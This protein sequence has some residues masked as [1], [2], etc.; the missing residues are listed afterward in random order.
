MNTAIICS[1]NRWRFN[2]V[3]ATI[4]RQ[5]VN[6]KGGCVAPSTVVKPSKSQSQISSAVIQKS[7]S[8]KGDEFSQRNGGSPASERTELNDSRISVDTSVRYF[9]TCRLSE[10]GANFVPF[11]SAWNANRAFA[12]RDSIWMRGTAWM[13]RVCAETEFVL[14]LLRSYGY[15]DQVSLVDWAL[16]VKPSDDGNSQPDSNEATCFV[17]ASGD[18]ATAKECAEAASLTDREPRLNLQRM[19]TQLKPSR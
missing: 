8:C 5:P 16:T 12:R 15:F 19:S 18:R 13:S 2:W 14:V 11:W 7:G 6:P 4:S 1:K 3:H 10:R 9:E 17:Y